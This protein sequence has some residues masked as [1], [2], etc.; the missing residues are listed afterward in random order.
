MRNMDGRT[1]PSRLSAHTLEFNEFLVPGEVPTSNQGLALSLGYRSRPNG[2]LG[3]YLDNTISR[4]SKFALTPLSSAL[5][6]SRGVPNTP[7]FLARKDK[8]WLGKSASGG[9]VTQH[10]SS[11][12]AL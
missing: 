8:G 6:D 4:R 1:T 10:P 5:F 12:N 2:Q 7:D 11:P 9:A 3:K